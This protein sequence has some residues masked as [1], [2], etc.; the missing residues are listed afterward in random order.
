MFSRDPKGEREGSPGTDAK[1]ATMNSD[2]MNPASGNGPSGRAVR[3]WLGL[4]VAIWV[5]VQVV[6]IIFYYFLMTERALIHGA[7]YRMYATALATAGLA[8]LFV[9]GGVGLI[10]NR[11]WG[12]RTVLIGACLQIA[13]TV[14]TQVW[15][16][17][18]PLS[19]QPSVIN[20]P[21]GAPLGILLWSVIPVGI[22]ILAAAA[23][24]PKAA[25][26]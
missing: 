11:P 25:A 21:L 14:A 23:K 7:C 18:T 19:N 26:A 9:V 13:V 2:E 15:E 12:P 5:L 4:L 20:G 17:F 1:G 24:S 16:V 22:L 3:M 8:M 10:L 6:A